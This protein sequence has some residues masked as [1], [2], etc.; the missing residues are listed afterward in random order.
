[1]EDS[2]P[3]WLGADDVD[4]LNALRPVPLSGLWCKLDVWEAVRVG[5]DGP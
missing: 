1:L 3:D 4:S 5:T 2:D